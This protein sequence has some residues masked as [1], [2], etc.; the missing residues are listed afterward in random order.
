MKP[1]K[2]Y[3]ALGDS[4]SI[5]LYPSLDL[6]HDA[7]LPIGAASLFFR[8]HDATWPEMHGRDLFT[9]Y[10]GIEAL[11]LTFD[12]AVTT[13]VLGSQLTRMK[14]RV[15]AGSSVLVTLT[16]GGNDL[17]M[18]LEER[19]NLEAAVDRIAS[20]FSKCLDRIFEHLPEAV[21]LVTTVYDPTDGTGLLPW[22]GELYGELPIEHLNTYNDHV[23]A[24]ADGERVLI[25]DAR[26][27]FHGHGREA[28]EGER[29]YWEVNPIEPNA[30][31]A[32][33]LR[34]LWLAT[35][36]EGR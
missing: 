23:R 10:P 27:H 7:G 21:T 25:A 11:D 18:A 28:P 12:G 30:R 24:S 35:L 3:I 29:W 13:D 8:N 19:A 4:M 9:R 2:F 32:D 6:R 33:E 16:A 31:G 26:R 17:L 15:G 1:P 20:N 22:V 34:K 5:D 36:G 14:R